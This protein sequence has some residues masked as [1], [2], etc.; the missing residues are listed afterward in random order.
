MFTEKDVNCVVIIVKNGAVYAIGPTSE[1]L[2]GEWLDGWVPS[3][4]LLESSPAFQ[5]WVEVAFGNR[6][7]V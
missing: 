4:I 7:P 2:L 5:L 3:R 1:T 6:S